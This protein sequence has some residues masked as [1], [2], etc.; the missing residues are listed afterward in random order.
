MR[1]VIAFGLFLALSALAPH[2]RAELVNG[3]EAV[4]HDSVITYEQVESLTDDALATL[5][6]QHGTDDAA[7]QKK[8]N[9]ARNNNLDNLVARELILHEFKTSGY[10]VPDNVIDELVR[11][12]LRA[13]FG[14]RRTATKTLRAEGINYETFR[15]RERDRLILEV[16]RQKNLSPEKIII[17]PQKIEDYYR[18]HLDQFQVEDQV[19]LRSIV[20][21]KRSE[22]S[23]PQTRKLLEEILAKLKEGVPFAELAALHSETPDRAQG[24]ARNWERVRSLRK[25]LATAVAAL[26]PGQVSDVIE[27]SDSFWIVRVEEK[28]P[29]HARPLNE[30]R[31]QIERELSLA[32]AKRI[33]DQWI[34]KLKKKTF[35]RY[36]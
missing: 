24:G 3:I 10:S 1:V 29:A 4:V 13:M 12:R 2:G 23:L 36:F 34:E 14:D 30:V 22:E 32:E 18:G 16:M 15:E 17:S 5:R 26:A 6:R 27:T 31:D 11:E 9:D 35:V 19:K 7:F 33:E 28:S 25:E 20:I 21:Y 8:L